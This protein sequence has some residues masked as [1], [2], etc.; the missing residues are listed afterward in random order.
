MAWLR[1]E[2]RGTSGSAA[3]GMALKYLEAQGLKL[4]E[5]NFRCRVGEIDLIMADGGTLV[6]VEVRLRT[7]PA[8]VSAG[9]SISHRKQ[10]RIVAAANQFLAGKREV[11]CRFDCVLLDKLEP[12][13]IEW[14]KNAFGA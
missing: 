6:F 7:N 10:A 13:A 1:R 9:E 12:E 3:E 2:R 4:V 5:R 8:F 14:I 11:P